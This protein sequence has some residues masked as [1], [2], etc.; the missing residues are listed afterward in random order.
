MNMEKVK[1]RRKISVL[2]DKTIQKEIDDAWT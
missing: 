2:V 1:E